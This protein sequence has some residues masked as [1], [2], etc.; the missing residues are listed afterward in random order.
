MWP[1]N[2]AAANSAWQWVSQATLRVSSHD[3]CHLFWKW[4]EV[5]CILCWNSDW[6]SDLESLAD[7]HPGS[8]GWVGPHLCQRCSFNESRISWQISS[9]ISRS[10]DTIPGA[11]FSWY[12][13]WY[14][15]LT[16]SWVLLQPMSSMVGA[17]ALASHSGE[18]CQQPW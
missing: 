1:S 16:S 17:S 7:P 11:L 8:S 6:G 2:R 4:S 15:A 9:T 14:N 18:G 3:S 10:H 12:T 5:T 13:S